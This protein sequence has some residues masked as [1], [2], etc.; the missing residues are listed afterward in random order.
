[1]KSRHLIYLLVLLT[2]FASC[3][4]EERPTPTPFP[5]EDVT[6]EAL[7]P[8]T[9]LEISITDLAADPEA[10]ANRFI[11]L[12]GRYQRLPLL[13]C[14][15][16]PYP[17]PATWQLTAED[18]SLIAVGGFDSQLRSLL[19]NDLTMT[20][21]GVW[22]LFEGPVGCGKE[23]VNTQIWYLK[24]SDI[25]SPSPIARVTLTPTGEGSQIADGGEDTA[26][27]ISDTSNNPNA[28]PTLSTDN[29]SG[30]PPPAG[31]PVSGSTATPASSGNN[32]PTGSP[33]SSTGG[34]G[35]GA[36]PTNTPTSAANATNTPTAAS[37]G[38]S[39]PT[40]TPAAGTATPTSSSGGGGGNPTP[41]SVVLSTATRN[42]NDFDTVEFDDLSP[43]EPVLELLANEE[44]HL[45]PI[46]F[47]NTG[48]ITVTAIAE[49]TVN[50]VL[51]IIDPA[52][53]VVQQANSGGDG[54]LESIVNAQ[55]NVAL[56]YQIRVYDLNT[57]GGEYCLIFSEAGGFPDSIKGRLEYGQTVN[58]TIEVLAINYWCF[59]GSDGDDITISASAIGGGGDFVVGLFGPPDFAAIGN[60]FTD[61]ELANI[62]L[63]EDGMYLIGVLDFEA[64]EAAYSLTL[65]E[66]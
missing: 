26:V 50:L 10:F 4:G 61:D 29:D 36:T 18:G 32:T 8:A 22:Q 42:P 12:T 2:I 16:D 53:D 55:L 35:S 48:A 33:T 52:D 51:E 24:V 34:S 37:G 6:E 25:I 21:A 54:A 28:T 45:W 13:V 9:P 57:S 47:E 19:P 60:V 46:L 1:M 31:T 23:A 20:V 39:T 56:D 41:T 65:T 38:G 49:P 11:E 5:D 40:T 27:S 63:E 62:V 3:N 66:N 7:N 15:T 59:L 43:E 14:D 30:G 64:G 58:Q 17:A 44:A